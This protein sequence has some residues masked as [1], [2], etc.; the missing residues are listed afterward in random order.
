MGYWTYYLLTIALAYG[1]QHPALAGLVLELVLVEA[2]DP[3]DLVHEQHREEP[4]AVATRGGAV[5]FTTNV[6]GKETFDFDV[7]G[8]ITLSSPLTIDKNLTI[9]GP[10]ANVLG[11]DLQRSHGLVHQVRTRFPQGD[12]VFPRV[13]TAV[14]PRLDRAAQPAEDQRVARPVAA[15][16]RD[17]RQP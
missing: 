7:T 2:H 1:T 10:G 12:G 13:G 15:D 14:R 16:H 4:D 17:R 3:M 6:P 9:S 11:I 8:T 5:Q